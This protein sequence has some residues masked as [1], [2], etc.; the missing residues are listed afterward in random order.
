MGMQEKAVF[1]VIRVEKLDTK[2][3]N[4]LK[5]TFL[6]KGGDVAVS[7]HSADLSAAY[8]DVLLMGTLKQ[9]RAALNQLKLQPW[10]FFAE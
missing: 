5:Q 4:V 6:G 8:T 7:R 10:H 3:A 2:A 9:Y 1:K